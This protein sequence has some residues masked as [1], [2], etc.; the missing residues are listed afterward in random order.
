MMKNG[1]LKELLNEHGIPNSFDGSGDY[2]T[3]STSMGMNLSKQID[4]E[5]DKDDVLIYGKSYCPFT[6]RA[7][8]LFETINVDYVDYEIDLMENGEEIQEVLTDKTR[9]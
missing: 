6:K 3:G 8:A 2:S 7:R 5:I 9:Q 1:E 4:A